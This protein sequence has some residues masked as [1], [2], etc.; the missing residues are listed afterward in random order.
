[1]QHLST[2]AVNVVGASVVSWTTVWKRL[3]WKTYQV[4][5]L[6]GTDGKTE[7][8]FKG[9]HGVRMPWWWWWW[10]HFNKFAIVIIFDNESKV[11]N[12]SRGW[13]KGSLFNSYHT[14]GL[15]RVLLHSLFHFTLHPCLIILSVQQGDIK[16]HFLSL[17]YDST[18]DWTQVSQ[19]IGKTLPIRPIVQF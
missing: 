6:I 16:Y 15:G 18:W 17:L 10:F 12:L 7:R 8:N 3:V 2:L 9:I 1:M 11:G 4:W 13:P 5:W 14:K 19:T